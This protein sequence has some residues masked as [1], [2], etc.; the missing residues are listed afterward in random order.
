MKPLFPE[1]NGRLVYPPLLIMDKVLCWNV[2]GLNAPNKKR[3]VENKVG[4][5][6]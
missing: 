1:G 3:S 2:R 4:L 5:I 6:D